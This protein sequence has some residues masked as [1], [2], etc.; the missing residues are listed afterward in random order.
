MWEPT[1][2]HLQ[3]SWLT[4]RANQMQINQRGPWQHQRPLG[5]APL[6]TAEEDVDHIALVSESELL[7]P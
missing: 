2:L 1:T 5:Q 4:G 7:L 3:A 6:A